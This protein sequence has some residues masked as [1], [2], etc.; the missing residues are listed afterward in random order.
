MAGWNL[1]NITHRSKAKMASQ[2]YDLNITHLE[3][4]TIR[5][6]QGDYSGDSVIIDLHPVQAAFLTDNKPARPVSE[7]IT[8]L[9]RRLRWLRD[10]F[11]E[12][13]AALPPDMHE[14]CPEA[15]EF[16]SW[17]MASVD[18]ATEFCA[19]L[20]DPHP[21]PQDKPHHSALAE[22]SHDSGGVSQPNSLKLN[23]EPPMAGDEDLFSDRAG[24]KQ[25]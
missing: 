22:L 21:N 12:C 4:G 6:E 1:L 18:V 10:R 13:Y 3:D 5:L 15:P 2:F 11:E 16:S 24:S 17:L 9:E 20:N 7:R 23:R 14:R 8:T 19:D 25:V